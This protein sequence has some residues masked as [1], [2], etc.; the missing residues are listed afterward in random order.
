MSTT[1]RADHVAGVERAAVR[2]WDGVRQEFP[3]LPTCTAQVGHM[4]RR[5]RPQCLTPQWNSARDHIVLQLGPWIDNSAHA[6]LRA[7]LHAAAHALADRAGT[8]VTNHEGS[9]HSQSFLDFGK[10]V[11]LTVAPSS[12]IDQ[13]TG[14]ADLKLARGTATRHQDAMRELFRL[15]GDPR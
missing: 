14:Y 11:G 4:S 12:M 3:Q 6:V 2:I 1:Q 13:V 10:L 9:Y 5:A 8:S 15:L 7:V